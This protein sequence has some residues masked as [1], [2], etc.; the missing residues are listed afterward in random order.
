[1]V[2]KRPCALRIICP[3]IKLGALDRLLKGG[4]QSL[5]VITRFNL[6]DFAD[7]VSDIGALRRVLAAG[8]QV[9][10]IRGLHSKLYLF[11]SDRA[12]VT[13]ANLTR[14][15]LDRNHEFG[16]VVQDVAGIAACH[17]YFNRLWEVGGADV[18]L[19]QLKSWE[20]AVNQC[21]AAGG[22]LRA[23]THL[24]DFG[25]DAG[26]DTPSPAS[27]P[28]IVADATQAFVKFLGE[29]N[30]RV[31]VTCP[32]VEEIIRAGC[33]LVLAYPAKKR[34]RSVKDDALMFIARL[35]DEPDIRIFGRAVGM[36]YV[37]VRDDATPADVARR[38][39]RATWSRYIR[40]HQA[41]FIAGT[42]AN[43]VSLNELM[44]TL[45]ANAFA[46]TQRNI[47]AEEGNVNPRRAYLQAA[48]VQLSPQ[49]LAWLRDRLQAAFEQHGTVPQEVLDDI[50]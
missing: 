16:A 5:Q 28:S 22:R 20:E 39:W 23:R 41:E 26:I 9:R 27:L 13:S 36:L 4:P 12:I 18:S 37:P 14:A 17:S 40:V 24:G 42:M 6:D 3:F 46:A 35:T 19:A 21:R 48:A 30:N 33:H 31:P 32:T 1:M 50:D 11:G 8:G 25:V 29:S 34:P 38:A 15:A 7:G 47:D 43:G 49:G 2:C 10:G 45:G 44:V